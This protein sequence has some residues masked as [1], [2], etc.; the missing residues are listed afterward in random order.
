MTEIAPT[1]ILGD[2]RSLLLNRA[3]GTLAMYG[4]AREGD[5]Y[6]VGWTPR[7]AR[8]DDLREVPVD[9]S[10]PIPEFP[11]GT[12]DRLDSLGQ[13]VVSR[14]GAQSDYERTVALEVFCRTGYFNDG[15]D[16]VNRDHSPAGHSVR[17]LLDLVADEKR[18]I[19][20][21]EQYAAAMGYEL[22]RLG[23]PARVVL[24]FE[25]ANADGTVTGDDIAAWVEVPFSGQGWIPFDPTPKESRVPPPLTNDPNPKPQPYVVQP[26]VLPKD[27]GVVQGTPPEGGG[28]DLADRLWDVV[29]IVLGYLWLGLKIVLLLSPLWLILLVKQIRRHRRR[30]ADDLVERLSG[31]WREV[32]DAARD[33]GTRV[34]PGATR[35]EN[36]VLLAT[37][38]PQLEPVDLAASADRHV[39][40]PGAPSEAEVDAY[41]DD[42]DSA[43]KRMR[44][45]APWWRRVL[46]WFSPAS[47]PWGSLALRGR[48]R[49]LASVVRRRERTG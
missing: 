43:L 13:R 36:G 34:T 21:D 23:I 22:Q 7:P 29:L 45:S 20:N 17:R 18:M 46:A 2:G 9:V 38:F 35:R 30:S 33:L 31:A 15:D 44:S 6:A 40:G 19:G 49:S 11:F 42:V 3:T 28:Q 37:N 12:V 27:P 47:I 41:W 10:A 1:R 4:G 39:F 26:P 32:T 48:L 16:P 25:G 8:S 5:V 24:G 14:A